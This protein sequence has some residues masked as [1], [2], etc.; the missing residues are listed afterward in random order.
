MDAIKEGTMDRPKMHIWGPGRI[1]KVIFVDELER[2]EA[3]GWRDHPDKL[4][5]PVEKPLF[6]V[7]HGTQHD[8]APKKGRRASK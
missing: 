4:G 3:N 1:Q 5:K 2:Y 8:T 7:S 6:G